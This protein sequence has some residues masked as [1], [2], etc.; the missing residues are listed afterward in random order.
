MSKDVL[1]P[2]EMEDLDSSSIP[3]VNNDSDEHGCWDCAYML[4][5]ENVCMDSDNKCNWKALSK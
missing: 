2:W 1:Y 4:R 3:V 5:E